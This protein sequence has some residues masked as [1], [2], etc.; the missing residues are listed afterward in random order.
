MC[1][2]SKFHKMRSRCDGDV[3]SAASSQRSDG[4][5]NLWHR[6]NLKCPS[7]RLGVGAQIHEESCVLTEWHDIKGK[8]VHV[9]NAQSTEFMHV[10]LQQAG[11]YREHVEGKRSF[12]SR[13]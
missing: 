5:G 12:Q 3:V 8:Q 2:P 4:I 10:K 6:V 1:R 9:Q 7:H 13:H 11:L